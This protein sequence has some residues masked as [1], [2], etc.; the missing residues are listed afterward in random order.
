MRE[1]P[2]FLTPFMAM[3]ISVVVIPLMMRVAPRLG[4][5]DLPNARKVHAAAVPRIGGWG[6]LLGA[7]VPVALVFEMDQT[8]AAYLLGALALLAFGAADDRLN[9]GH[10][11]KFLGQLLA[12]TPLVVYGGVYVEHLPLMGDAPLP[13]EIGKPF[14]VFAMVGVINA[15]NHSDGLDGLAAGEALMS[16]LAIAFLAFLASDLL[17]GNSLPVGA[18][19]TLVLVT[20]LCAVGGLVGFL[21]FNTHPARVFMGDTGSQFLGYTLA[22]LVVLLTQRVEPP[23]NPALPALLLGLPVIDILVVLFLRVRGGM[24]WFK[25]TRNHIHHRL[26]DIGLSHQEAVVIIYSVQALFVTSAVLLRNQPQALILALYAGAWVVIFTLLTLGERAGWRPPR[27]ARWWPWSRPVAHPQA[28][29]AL[30]SWPAMALMVAVP[31]YIAGGCAYIPS[32]PR[33]FGIVSLLLLGV[34]ALERLIGGEWSAWVQRL[35]VYTAAVFIVYLI[36]V[37]TETSSSLADTVNQVFF[38]S[39]A[40]CVM[41]AVRYAP[42]SVFQ[43]TPTDYLV[44]FVVMVLALMLTYDLILRPEHAELAVKSIIMLYAC[45]ILLARWSHRWTA[46]SVASLGALGVLGLRGL[47]MS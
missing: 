20:A 42:G 24:N 46:L 44:V 27:G 36:G 41:L 22:F 18:T 35:A 34:I 7:I 21:R 40:A 38:W 10:Y 32:V 30:T 12:V 45:E 31:L 39:L 26:L 16:L 13:P 47:L 3:A 43:T 4:M 5:V 11:T 6:V 2:P 29:S 28:G 15:I 1:I 19:E 37:G 14:T 33:D 8:L 23:L 25:G 17:G 9:I